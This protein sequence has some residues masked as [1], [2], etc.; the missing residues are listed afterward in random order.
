MFALFLIFL[1]RFK[2]RYLA[3]VN[4]KSAKIF[5]FYT[6]LTTIF[7]FKKTYTADEM[8]PNVQERRFS[9]IKVPYK[10]YIENDE[11][12]TAQRRSEPGTKCYYKLP[13]HIS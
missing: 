10:F 9:F 8:C 4:Y 3:S 2:E 1:L 12:F 11:L 13:Q 5:K 6:K 7:D